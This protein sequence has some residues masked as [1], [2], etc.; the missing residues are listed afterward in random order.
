M[1]YIVI[2]NIF[3]QK[4]ENIG[5][6]LLYLNLHVATKQSSEGHNLVLTASGSGTELQRIQR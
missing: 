6:G 1:H 2:V 3:N 5:S 4:I